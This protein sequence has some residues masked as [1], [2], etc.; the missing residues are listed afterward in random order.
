MKFL[1]IAALLASTVLLM[2]STTN[3]TADAKADKPQPKLTCCQQAAAEGKECKHRCCVAAH[4]EGKSC[5]KCNPNK[6]DLKLKPS[7]KKSAPKAD[8]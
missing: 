2:G 1:K 7:N 4:R 6:E 8:N 5:E 3:S